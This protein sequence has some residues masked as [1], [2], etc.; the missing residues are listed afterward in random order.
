MKDELARRRV[1]MVGQSPRL[2]DKWDNKA[3]TN[4]WLG[5]QKGLEGAFPK[6]R[7][8]HK[9]DAHEGL[10]LVKDGIGWPK[11]LKPVRGRG[12]HG[13]AVVNNEG[14]FKKHL[15]NLYSEFDVALVEVSTRSPSCPRG[16]E[17]PDSSM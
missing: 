3:E 4:S 5:E 1:R 8:L 15:D 11:V 12:S 14:E 10:E 7:V 2:T 17:R 9:R 16:G 13:V 6:S